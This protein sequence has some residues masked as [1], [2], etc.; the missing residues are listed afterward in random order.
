VITQNA[1][2]QR[3]ARL[4]LGAWS[5]VERSQETAIADEHRGVHRHDHRT[6]LTVIVHVDAPRGRGSAR[7]DLDAFDGSADDVID[8]ALAL[9]NAAI[10]PAWVSAPAAAPAN[11]N[12]VDASLVQREL[13]AAA[14]NTLVALHRPLPLAVTARLE[15]ARE[16]ITVIASSGFRFRWLATHARAHATLRPRAAD[17]PDLPITTSEPRNPVIDFHTPALSRQSPS[18]PIVRQARRVDD[19]DLDAA[20]TAASTDLTLLTDA[21]PPPPAGPYALWLGPDAILPDDDLGLWTIFAHHADAAIERQGL[22]RLHLHTELA[23]GAAQLA[24]PLSIISDGALDFAT[25]STPVADDAVAVR[26][27]PIIERGLTV[28]LGLSSRE[29]ALRATD[30]NGG[31]RNLIVAPGTWRPEPAPRPTLEIRRLFALTIDPLTADASLDIALGLVHLPDRSPVPF[32]G[33]TIH[34]DLLTTLALA[35]RSTQL[36]RRGAYHGPAHLLID[37]ADLLT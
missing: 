2:A 16:T 4:N 31:T 28:G 10:G 22:T 33:G 1:L 5:V 6:R 7:L 13:D 21:G 19:L 14:R 18:L 9:A 35:R 29:A 32:T 26:R 15:L 34:L 36:L 25:R 3:L 37:S 23:A 11:V 20:I 8:Q 30:P 24:E 12:V 27:F 17:N